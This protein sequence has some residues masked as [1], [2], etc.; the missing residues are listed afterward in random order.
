V[1]WKPIKTAPGST[2]LL[3]FVAGEV[4]VGIKYKCKWWPE[5][6]EGDP[7]YR[8]YPSHWMPLPAP[9]K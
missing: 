9:P 3:L 2:P 7:D 5:I 6:H 1:S 8:I 4:C